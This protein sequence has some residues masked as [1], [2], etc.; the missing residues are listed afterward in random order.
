MIRY[1]ALAING[2]VYVKLH[3]KQA[4]RTKKLVLQLCSELPNV[5]VADAN[6]HD[7]IETSSVIVSQ[8]SAVGFEALMYRKPVV[9]CG[10]IDYH[11]ATLVARTVEE[12]QE[13]VQTAPQRLRNFPY[14]H[15]FY[16]FLAENMLEPQK[17]DFLDRF[18]TRIAEL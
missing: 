13:C 3:P 17:E 4:D 5:V 18:W 12:L 14:E 7:L 15:Y 9:T 10:R 1:T 2:L 16:W 11:H 8:N 6:V